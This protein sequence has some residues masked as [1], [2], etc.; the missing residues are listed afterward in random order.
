MLV[1]FGFGVTVAQKYCEN[2][3]DIHL[4]MVLIKITQWSDDLVLLI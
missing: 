1:W 3:I 4:L 2:C